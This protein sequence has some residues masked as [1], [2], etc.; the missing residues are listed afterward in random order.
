MNQ[1]RLI[2][3]VLVALL[4]L[5]AAAVA[6]APRTFVASTGS[7]S[8]PCSRVA[9]CRTFDAALNAVAPGGEIVPLD[10]AGFGANLT[11]TK[12]VSIIAPDGV[13]AGVTITT[14]FGIFINAGPS[15][16]ITL[17]GLTVI[18]QSGDAD[19]GVTF[20]TGGA[21]HVESCVMTGFPNGE[22]INF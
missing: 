12:A 11:I 18:G 22:G 16:S 15:D 21:L 9:P 4:L 2:P 3:G 7:D 5:S 8:N 13:Y 19:S 20:L 1:I 14:G 17:R 6:Q 10:S